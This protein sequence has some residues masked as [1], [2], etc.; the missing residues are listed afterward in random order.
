MAL[1][2]QTGAPDCTAVSYA[3]SRPADSGLIYAARFGG[4]LARSLLNRAPGTLSG[5]SVVLPAASVAAGAPVANS[6]YLTMSLTADLLDTLVEENALNLTS[7]TMMVVARSSAN[8]GSIRPA[9]FARMGTGLTG[10]MMT[11][12]G[13]GGSPA[14]IISGRFNV[15]ASGTLT[16]ITASLPSLPSFATWNCI[17]FRVNSGVGAR[18]KNFTSN[19]VT[20]VVETRTRRV[21]ANS[22]TFKVGPQIDGNLDVISAYAWSRALTDAEMTAEYTLE[23]AYA[24]AIGITI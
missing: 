17:M 23:Q 16:N 15:D 9:M 20:D 4:T 14:A 13:T 19:Q 21:N 7:F 5:G 6:G 12:V 2:I 1:R 8:F 24:A 22:N 18:I 3:M 11:G 10:I